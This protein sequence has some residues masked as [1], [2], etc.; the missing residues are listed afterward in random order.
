[1][2]WTIYAAGTEG[3]LKAQAG[4]IVGADKMVDYLRRKAFLSIARS[5]KGISDGVDIDA[6]LRVAKSVEGRIKAN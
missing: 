2:N 6:A 1:M 5:I 3:L 4:D